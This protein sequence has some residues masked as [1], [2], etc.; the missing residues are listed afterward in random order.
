MNKLKKKTIINNLRNWF[1]TQVILHLIAYSL[2]AITIGLGCPETTN[3]L[4][5]LCHKIIIIQFMQTSFLNFCAS[6]RPPR[7]SG[8]V[9]KS[10]KSSRR[11]LIIALSFF[12][13]SMDWLGFDCICNHSEDREVV[14]SSSHCKECWLACFASTGAWRNVVEESFKGSTHGSSGD[15]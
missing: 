3:T 1:R 6:E 9:S 15:T 10:C 13:S 2:N 5:S 4:I 12:L 11:W 8:T 14:A 7:D